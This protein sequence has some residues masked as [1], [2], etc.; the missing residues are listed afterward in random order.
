MNKLEAQI[1]DFL[2]AVSPRYS[3]CSVRSYRIGLERFLAF[4]QEAELSAAG[5]LTDDSLKGFESWLCL[6]R[7]ELAEATASLWLRA[8]KLFLRWS[9]RAGLTLYDGDSYSPPAGPSPAPTPPTVAVMRRLLELPNRSTVMGLRDGFVLELLYNLGLRRSECSA[10]DLDDLDLEQQ[11]LRVV[12]KG[13]DERLL[14]VSPA[15]ELCAQD[16]LCNSRPALVADAA[17][18]ALFLNQRKQRLGDQSA[19]LIVRKYGLKL[20][21]NLSAHQLRHACATHLVEAGMELEHIQQLLGHSNLDSTRRYA[22]V[23]Q[24]QL[25][26]EFRRCRPRTQSSFP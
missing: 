8:A 2:A 20:G 13:G 11:T 5:D 4:C 7:P 10:L 15:L 24:R 12:G 9:C 23:S 18:R 21:L 26:R 25:E 6:N 19:N 14:P 16:Y 22:Q 17:E 3:P 1:Q